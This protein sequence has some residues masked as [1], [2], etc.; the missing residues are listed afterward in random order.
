MWSYL[1]PLQHVMKACLSCYFLDKTFG[2]SS[3]WENSLSQG[4]LG[5]LTKKER[6]VF[7]VICSFVQPDS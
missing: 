1:F 5:D 2:E 4:I 6:L 7:E 3:K